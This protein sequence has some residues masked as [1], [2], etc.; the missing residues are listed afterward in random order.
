M[1]ASASKIMTGIHTP[2]ARASFL[3][4]SQEVR[5]RV[6]GHVLM[7]DP[8][9]NAP[10][11]LEVLGKS[12]YYSNDY[13]QAVTLYEAINIYVDPQTV[14]AWKALRFKNMLKLRHCRMRWCNSGR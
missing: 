10:A 14:D 12:R 13:K 5:L 1:N 2:E 9:S 4:L 6:Y 11:L 3:D 8:S 7:P